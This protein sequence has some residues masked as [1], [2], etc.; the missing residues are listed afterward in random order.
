MSGEAGAPLCKVVVV[1]AASKKSGKSTVAA[2]LVRE[3]GADYG[4][5]VSA[6]GTH[7]ELPVTSDPG[8]ISRPGTDTGALVAAGARTVLWVNSPPEELGGHLRRALSMLTP[9][10]LLVIEGG[11]VLSHLSAHYA[12]FLMGVP[13]E[14]FKPSARMAM[15]KADLVLVNLSGALGGSDRSWLDKEIGARAPGASVFFY[16]EDSFS[17][18]LHEATRKAKAHLGA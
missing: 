8:I 9:P 2:H 10:G 4:L 18:A 13:F 17:E 1:S 16:D 6:G 12:V 5:K 3:L 14:D 11:S 7:A 15:E